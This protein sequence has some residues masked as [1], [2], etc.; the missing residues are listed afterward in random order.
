MEAGTTDSTGGGGVRVPIADDVGGLMGDDTRITLELEDGGVTFNESQDVEAVS[1]S[2]DTPPPSVV[3]VSGTTI[4]LETNGETDAGDEFRIQRSGGE[5]LRF[6][7]A[8]DANDT[9]LR[10]TTTPG[11]ENVTQVTGEVVTITECSSVPQAIAGEDDSVNNP[12]LAYAVDLW[13][14]GDEVPGTCGETIDDAQISS[15][16]DAWRTGETV[17]DA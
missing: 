5:A 16:K 3:N 14:E 7:A 8:P 9:A 17:N 1:V 15:L 11:A 6:D 2:G 4:V 10:V 13:R 12:E